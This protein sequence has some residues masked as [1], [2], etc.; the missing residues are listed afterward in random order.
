MKLKP[1]ER[2]YI[3]LNSTTLIAVYLLILVGGIVRS[4]GA[5]MGCPDWPKCFGSYVPPSN[6]SELPDDYQEIY[7]QK[8]MQKNLRVSRML[9][10]LGL[11]RM[12]NKVINDES[13]KEEQ[14]FNFTKTWIEYGNRILGVLV[15]FLIV[16]CFVSSLTFFKY[17][18]RVVF[19]SFGA[20]L[21][22]GFQGWTGS[23]VVSTNLLPGIITFH[24]ILAIALIAMLIYVRFL[25]NRNSINGLITYKPYK[26]KNYKQLLK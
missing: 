21:L 9:N 26:I 5:G 14:S 22:V 25:V 8:R 23:I 2:L 12:A 10:A 20:V 17:N 18:K 7:A 19:L 15:G 6:P 3:K 13:V 1:N 11:E 16:A 24:M 4:T